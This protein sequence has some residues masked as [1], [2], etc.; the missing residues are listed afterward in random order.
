M[1][2]VILN[3]ALFAM[4]IGMNTNAHAQ[5]I[6]SVVGHASVGYSGDGGLASS[7]TI[8]S[9][10]GVAMDSHRNMYV[11]DCNNNVVRKVTPT[12]IIT[13]VA[14]TGLFGYS[15]DGGAAVAAKL[16]YPMG[17]AVDK[18]NNLYIADDG[19]F[20]VRKVDTL[21]VISTVAGD[22]SGLFGTTGDGGPATAARFSGVV[23][24][25]F[26]KYSNMYIADGNTRIRKVNTSGIISTV[27]GS[28]LWG[29]T[30]D[31]SAAVSA[32]LA[33]P[34]SLAVD[35]LGNIYFTDQ[36]NN[37]VRK[38]SAAG[39]ITTLAGTGEAGFTGDGGSA[40]LAKMNNPAGL[41]ID[42][43][44]NI[45]VADQG[46]NRIRKI[47]A[48]GLIST[49]AGTGAAD[50]AGDG[51]L[52]V[53]AKLNSPAA[54][55]LNSN[56]DLFI[57]D[58]SNYAVRE[59]VNPSSTLITSMAGTEICNSTPT[60]FST[61]TVNADYGINYQ[62]TVNAVN[63]GTDSN[64]YYSATLHDGDDIMVALID[65]VTGSVL[66]HS[67]VIHMVVNSWVTPS[68]SIINTTGSVISSGTPVTFTTAAVNG[69]TIPSYQWRNNGV[70]IV[71]ATSSTYT[72]ASVTASDSIIC[73]L[74]STAPCPLPVVVTSN[75]LSV[76]ISTEVPMVQTA[77]FNVKLM[78]N[79]NSGT[80]NIEANSGSEE[81]SQLEYIITNMLGQTV[82]TNT[83]SAQ[84]GTFNG[85]IALDNKLPNGIYLLNARSG[86]TS[87]VIPFSVSK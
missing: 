47:N 7:A 57:A 5:V 85:Q 41:T 34:V 43:A 59:I 53:A 19:N 71:S 55:C 49:I 61:H 23:A 72:A 8:G 70:A 44:G 83:M 16:Y 29:Y 77:T 68:I 84:N 1:K 40:L 54:L 27:A 33:G 82:Y 32:A 62:W 48:S 86:N 11:A 24:I 6:R 26:D 60:V 52:A 67:N 46:N 74:T 30:G 51:G 39:I 81:A 38:V 14:G 3:F 22:G 18:Y 42:N 87:S 78:P 31:G 21:G 73:V 37:V 79:P 4:A 58:N 17:V 36:L 35:T 75:T 25:T 76:T 80:F 28:S 65:P 10:A 45:F 12:G 66:D 50:F 13:T 2:K 64:S 69:G 9:A 15:G 56:G 20:V 63:V